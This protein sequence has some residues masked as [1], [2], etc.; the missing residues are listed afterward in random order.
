MDRR[1]ASLIEETR[2]HLLVNAITD[3]AIYMLDEDG[4]VCSWNAGARR[5]KGYEESEVIGQHLSIFYTDVDNRD[6]LPSQALA[7]AARDG[8]YEAEG[9]RVRKD[10]SRFWAHVMIQPILDRDGDRITGYA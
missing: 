9:W 2:F 1:D 10:G 8:K 6:G 5:F 3:Y 4:R 7:T